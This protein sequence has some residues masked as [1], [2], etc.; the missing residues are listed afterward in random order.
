M[1]AVGPESMSNK[2]N[3]LNADA[4]IIQKRVRLIDQC[5]QRISFRKRKLGCHSFANTLLS[6]YVL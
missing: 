2:C 6:E 5:K 4:P 1:L 3:S